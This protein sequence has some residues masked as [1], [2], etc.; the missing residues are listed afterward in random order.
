MESETAGNLMG[1]EGL[2]IEVIDAADVKQRGVPLDVV[3]RIASGEKELGAIGFVLA[4]TSC[5]QGF[6]QDA[7]SP[8]C[9]GVGLGQCRVRRARAKPGRIVVRP[10]VI[11]SII[12]VFRNQPKVVL[13][14]QLAFTIMVIKLFVKQRVAFG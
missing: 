13:V 6:L 11:V 12:L 9:A 10:Y 14:T 3:D 1:D 7:W 8:R 5:E 4:G 2:L